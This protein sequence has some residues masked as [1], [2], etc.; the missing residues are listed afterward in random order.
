MNNDV[1]FGLPEN[2]RLAVKHL[3]EAFD[4]ESYRD[5]TSVGEIN[6]YIVADTAV[7]NALMDLNI[8]LHDAKADQAKGEK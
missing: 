6:A 2:V 1:P 4:E 7:S 8:D 5:G 3:R